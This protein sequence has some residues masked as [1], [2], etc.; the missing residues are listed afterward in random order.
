M[1]VTYGYGSAEINGA[2]VSFYEWALA[3]GQWHPAT[4]GYV[5][6]PGEV[7][8]YGLSVRAVRRFVRGLG[9]LASS[10]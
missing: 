2:A 4:S 5:A 6:A 10:R 1:N 3:N 8:V 7:A 9:R